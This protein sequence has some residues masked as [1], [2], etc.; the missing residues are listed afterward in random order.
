MWRRLKLNEAE[1]G[2]VITIGAENRSQSQDDTESDTDH[3]VLI[4]YQNT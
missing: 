1:S 2:I 3:C 4:Y